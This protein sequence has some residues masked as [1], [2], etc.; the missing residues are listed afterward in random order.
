MLWFVG[1][2][3]EEMVGRGHGLLVSQS[4]H[5]KSPGFQAEIWTRYL[6][7]QDTDSNDVVVIIPN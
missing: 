4:W 7:K 3:M 5:N 2:E 6:S 1:Y